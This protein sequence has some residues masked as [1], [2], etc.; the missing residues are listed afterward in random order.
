MPS[1]NAGHKLHIIICASLEQFK[2]DLLF[3]LWFYM[4][5]TI[6]LINSFMVYIFYLIS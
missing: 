1:L 5:I 2:R 3:T 4:L 6:V